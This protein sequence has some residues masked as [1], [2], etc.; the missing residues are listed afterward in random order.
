MV[1]EECEIKFYDHHLCHAASAAYTSGIDINEKVLA[2]TMDGI[3]DNTSVAVWEVY[4]NKIKNL[5]RIDGKGSLGWFYGLATEGLEWRH[6][7][8]EWKVMGL[9]PFGTH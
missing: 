5:L 1:S 3:G 9:A 7:S 6:G 8:E 4:K 2:F